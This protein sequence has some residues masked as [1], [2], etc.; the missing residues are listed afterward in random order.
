MYSMMNLSG[1]LFPEVQQFYRGLVAVLLQVPV[2]ARRSLSRA[3]W[4]LCP[5]T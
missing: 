4:R 5:R 2:L 3:S 1:I